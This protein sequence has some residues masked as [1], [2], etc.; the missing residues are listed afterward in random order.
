MPETVV[1]SFT[2]AAL[3]CIV[4]FHLGK[5]LARS[6][7]SPVE[8]EKFTTPIVVE[9]YQLSTEETEGFQ[10]LILKFQDGTG[11]IFPFQF[12]PAY[13]HA[14]SDEMVKH[15]ARALAPKG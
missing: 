11:R 15:A 10:K 5:R 4:A 9:E 7:A 13:A 8:I 14:L 6:K 1:L 3:A 2:V 12:H